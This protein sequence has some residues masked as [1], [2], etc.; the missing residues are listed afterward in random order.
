[1]IRGGAGTGGCYNAPSQTYCR[2]NCSR[3][4]A[5][6]ERVLF[7]TFTTSLAQDILANLRTLC[8]EHLSSSPPRV[9]VIN[10]DR[11]VSQFLKRKKFDRTVAYFG[12]DRDHLDEIWRD[13]FLD[14]E[15]PEGL[16]EEF[17]KAEWSQIVQAKGIQDQQ[18]YFKVPRTG[19]GTPLDRKKRALLWDAF[20]DYRAV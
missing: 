9:E 16:S 14:H 7:T 17:V 11:W 13:V 6:W 2:P 10:L 12:E 3:P 15:L 1:M 8:P 18:S 4:A 20:S 19:R 5:R